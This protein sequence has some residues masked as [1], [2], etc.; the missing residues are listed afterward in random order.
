MFCLYHTPWGLLQ[1]RAF[2]LCALLLL[3]VLVGCCVCPSLSGTSVSGV[4]SLVDP[5]DPLTVGPSSSGYAGGLRAN[6]D[7]GMAPRGLG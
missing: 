6:D 1:C 2:R 3:P 4:T 5:A 7:V